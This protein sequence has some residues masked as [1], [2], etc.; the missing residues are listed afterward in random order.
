MFDMPT[1]DNV[2]IT[3]YNLIGEIVAQVEKQKVSSVNIPIDLSEQATGVYYI[4]IQTPTETLTKKL[5][6]LR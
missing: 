4:R 1:T 6:L 3:V 2:K 5:S